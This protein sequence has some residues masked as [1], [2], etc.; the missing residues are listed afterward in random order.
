M[1]SNYAAFVFVTIA[2]AAA[3]AA[4]GDLGAGVASTNGL[5]TFSLAANPAGFCFAVASKLLI[6]AFCAAEALH[7]LGLVGDPMA[8]FGEPGSRQRRL[9]R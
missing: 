1:R 3:W 2:L 7:A 9:T 6:S 8:L 4:L 5:W